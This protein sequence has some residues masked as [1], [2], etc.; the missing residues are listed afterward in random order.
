MIRRGFSVL[1]ATAVGLG[2]VA[3]PGGHVQAADG[4]SPRVS[5]ISA[6]VS[7]GNA[8]Y[9][10]CVLANAAPLGGGAVVQGPNG[11]TTQYQAPLVNAGG[12]GSGTYLVTASFNG[13]AGG[14]YQFRAATVALN[15]EGSPGIDRVT[16]LAPNSAG[17]VVANS[18]QI[19]FNPTQ[20]LSLQNCN[21]P[22][23]TGG[24][25]GDLTHIG[26]PPPPPSNTPVPPATAT[27]TPPPAIVPSSTPIPGGVANSPT[28]TTAPSTGNA[29][30]NT[31]VPVSAGGAST[32]ISGGP[33]AV[34]AVPTAT[35]ASS[36]QSTPNKKPSPPA[37]HGTSGPELRVSLRTALVKPGDLQYLSVSYSEDSLVHATILFPGS[38]ALSLYNATD[39]HGRLT[40]G[41]PVP[42][43]VTLRNG[44][45][46]APITV[47]AISGTWRQVSSRTARVK[48]GT[49]AHL[50]ITAPARTL[51]RVYITIPGQRT[52]TQYTM[53]GPH[54]QATLTIKVTR[55][56]T[57]RHGETSAV[58]RVAVWTVSHKR[59]AQV[60]RTLNISDMLVGV[61]PSAIADC[62]QT[63]AVQVRYQ[64]NVP[65]RV[66]LLFPGQHHLTLSARTDRQGDATVR[67]NVT[68]AQALSPLRLTVQASDARPGRRRMEQTTL[69][70]VLPPA[71]QRP[72]DGSIIVGG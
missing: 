6:S 27:N 32:P 39:A 7:N 23:G 36:G 16:P 62:R 56:M 47:Q 12:C 69:S 48:P 43:H 22:H 11:A 4:G 37:H 3:T 19:D 66:A 58:A 9:Y 8:V 38:Q 10:L 55:H 24:V 33:T 49:T 46:A 50:A 20:N 25:V 29:P 59:H 42:R 15:G 1:V 34:A 52:M 71:C 5:N 54:G 61:A 51:V 31:P 65:L 44:R 2:L 41:V 30:T 72:A 13:L 35:P 68:Y 21:P 40:F 17:D 67:V 53:T 60:N 57:L 70:V 45:A 63:Q 64:P 26:P 28:P 18:C 14:Q